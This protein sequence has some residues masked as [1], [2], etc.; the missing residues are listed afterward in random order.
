MNVVHIHLLMNH[1]PVIG[2]IFALILFAGTFYRK[3]VSLRFAL[4]FTAGLGAAALVVYLTGEPAADSVEKL[5][6]IAENNVDRHEE[7]AELATIV[8]GSL[9]AL[10]LIALV[11]FRR[12]EI[13][14][15]IGGAGLVGM[16][17]LS[18]AMGWT[19]NLGGRIR[20]SEI[21]R[22]ATAISGSQVENEAEQ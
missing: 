7:A 9:G 21:G 13:P 17:L 3:S 4:W 5:V 15:W 19:A 8:A 14:R 6:G 2:S 12:R 1:F 16:I 22:G 18:A 20:H 10:A 11:F